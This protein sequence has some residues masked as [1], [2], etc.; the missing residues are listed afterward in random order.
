[1]RLGRDETD[2]RCGDG[3][4]VDDPMP[5]D[6]IVDIDFFIGGAIL[7]EDEDVVADGYGVVEGLRYGWV[8]GRGGVL[9]AGRQ[10]DGEN[11]LAG[12]RNHGDCI[13]R[14]G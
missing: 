8:G 14:D 7:L 12:R 1:M 4:R 2:G 6:A 3:T 5:A 11:S 13:G 9:G 10:V